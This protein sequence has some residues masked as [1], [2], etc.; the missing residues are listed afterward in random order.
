MGA[1]LRL[2]NCEGWGRYCVCLWHVL[3]PAATLHKAGSASSLSRGEFRG[4]E[5]RL[6]ATGVVMETLW[7]VRNCS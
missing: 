7:L 1:N 4:R 2:E 6:P 3:R 5:S